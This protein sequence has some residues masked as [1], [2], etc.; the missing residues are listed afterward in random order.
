[1]TRILIHVEGQTEEEFVNE[2]LARHLVDRGYTSVTARLIGNSR[3][4]KRRGVTCAWTS[5]RSE[6]YRHLSKDTDA[7]AT[8]IVDFYALPANGDKAWPGRGACDGLSVADKA[9]HIQDALSQDMEAHH[10][11]AIANRFIPF[12]AMHEFEGLLFSD[13]T[14]MARGMGK[15]DL[16]PEFQ[17]IRDKFETPE[18]INDSPHT[19]PS[20]RIQAIIPKYDKVIYGNV[21]AL[22]VTLDRMREECPVFS[23]W[24]NSLDALP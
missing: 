12:V 22:E 15:S 8:T 19:A 2:V 10:G 7:Y 5:V 16:A 6:I 9:A 11:A 17:I 4:R 24:L 20:K 1:L 21:A 13:P 3:I 18:H 23:S 14:R